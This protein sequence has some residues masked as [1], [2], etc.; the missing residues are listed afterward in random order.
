MVKIEKSAPGFGG[1]GNKSP[2][3]EE[4]HQLAKTAFADKGEWY[5]IPLPDD[6]SVSRWNA[7][8]RHAMAHVAGNVSM[9]QGRVWMRFHKDSD[10]SE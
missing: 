9:K 2:F 4:L 8:V 3:G 1:P 6:R 5:S 10:A 7:S